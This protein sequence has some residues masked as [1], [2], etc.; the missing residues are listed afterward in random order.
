MERK[1]VKCEF[2]ESYEP[3]GRAWSGECR[4]NAPVGGQSRLWPEV[5]DNDWCG[6]FVQ[7]VVDDSPGV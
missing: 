4:K 3:E 2:Y 1:C 7:K 5:S 6:E